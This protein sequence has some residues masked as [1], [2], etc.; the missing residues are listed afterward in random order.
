MKKILSILLTLVSFAGYA[1][2][3]TFG[4]IGLRVNDSTTYVTNS[5]AYH[6]AG[7]ADLWYSNASDLWWRWNGSAY[8]I[9]LN[10]PILKTY[11]SNHT[12]VSGD[13]RNGEGQII[14][15][16]ASAA[17][18]TLSPDA[19]TNFAAGTN[20][21]IV[22][23]LTDSV[24]L[25]HP[26]VTINKCAT[27]KEYTR[28]RLTIMA[29]QKTETADTWNLF[30]TADTGSGG[31]GG[32]P[33]GSNTQVQYNASGAFAGEAAFTYNAST[34]TADVDV[35]T[36]DTEAYDATGWNGD[37]S[38]PTKDAVRDKIE[39]MGGGSGTVTSVG[40]TGGIVSVANPTTTPAF[41][42]A[43]T[44][45]GI[46][47]FSGSTTWASSAA[48]SANAIV[49]GGGAGTAPSTT[50]TGSGVLTALGNNVNTAS[51]F[52]TGSGTA[53]L[54]NKRI[55]PRLQSVTSSATVTPDADANDA[56]KITAQAA[57]L[58]LAN[59]T[60]TPD[61]MQ[62]MVIRI[63]DNGTAR[64]ITYGSQYRAVGVVLP[65]TTVISKVLY[66]GMVWNA[67]ESKWDVVGVQQE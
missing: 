12:I 41:T 56:V 63:K 7:Y 13:T 49:I 11:T 15:N 48:L 47:Y 43:G 59:P 28:G 37:L 22:Q 33:G 57:G 17:T 52:P 58:T 8:V 24:T 32:T 3:N 36:V 62:A 16:N 42:I 30:G 64:S 54:S 60:G 50:T 66:L 1:Q 45:G 34:N 29:L 18:V 10:L 9:D 38:V 19:T 6:S 31:G 51:G 26:G 23:G 65:T 14:M 27:C 53:T 21:Y 39:T 67:D 40:W 4:G 5:A 46:P 20:I 2:M 61:G 35:L 55:T 25:S 44:S